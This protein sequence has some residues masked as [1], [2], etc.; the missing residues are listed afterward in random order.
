MTIEILGQWADAQ[1]NAVDLKTVFLASL[2]EKFI[3]VLPSYILFPAIGAGAATS[4]NLVCRCLIAVLGSIGG[5]VGW[6]A[7]GVAIG[8]DRVRSFVERYGMWLFL[9]PKL[10]NQMSTSYRRNPFIITVLGQMVPTVRIF[11]A[12]PAGVLRLPFGSFLLATALGALCWISAL[13][14]AGYILHLQGWSVSE[15]GVGIFA[16]LVATEVV[17]LLAVVSAK[18]MRSLLSRPN[19]AAIAVGGRQ[20]VPNRS[21]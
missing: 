20:S 7:A 1:L 21:F 3:P 19:S 14:G 6:Y 15:T 4:Q 16:G 10:Y 2:V 18:K 12:L 5:A 13:A 9:R 8:E 11:H 17:A